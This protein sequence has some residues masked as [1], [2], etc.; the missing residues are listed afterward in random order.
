MVSVIS[1][2]FRLAY[3]VNKIVLVCGHKVQNHRL[4][5]AKKS[6]YKHIIFYVK[7]VKHIIIFFT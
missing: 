6:Y 5:H 3:F 1:V 4:T 2:E 7:Y